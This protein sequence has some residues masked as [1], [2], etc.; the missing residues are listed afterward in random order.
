MQLVNTGLETVTSK[1]MIYKKLA[2]HF[3][4][5]GDELL[6]HNYSRLA[7]EAIRNENKNRP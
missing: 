7:E 6:S 4:R 1:S 5:E 2:E 3:K